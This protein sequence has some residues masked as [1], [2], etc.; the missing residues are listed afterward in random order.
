MRTLWMLWLVI[1]S[2]GV[3]MP[4]YAGELL[5]MKIINRDTGRAL[6]TYSHHGK[7]YLAGQP[8]Q[9]YAIRLIV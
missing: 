1:G 2:L 6:P 3:S 4:L 9:R 5:E 7:T 8:K